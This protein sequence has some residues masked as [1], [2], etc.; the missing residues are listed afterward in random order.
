MAP[1]TRGRANPDYIANA[2]MAEHYAARAACGLIITEGTMTSLKSR[3]WYLAPEIYTEAHANGWKIVTD[4]VH[5]KNGRIFCQLWHTGR[6]GHSNFREGMKQFEDPRAVAPSAIKRASKDGMQRYTNKPGKVEIETPRALETEEVEMLKDE[7][8]N[9]AYWAKQAGFDGVELHCANGYLLDT[10][11]QSCSNERTDKY[12]GSLENRFRVVEEI[13]DGLF[14]VWDKEY[15]GVRISPNGIFNGMGSDD[16]RESFLY[17]AKR[18]AEIGVG[19]LHVMIGLG[20]G[21]HEKGT[22]M[23]MKEFRDVFPGVIIA[24]VDY[25]AETAEKEI[26]EGNADIVAFGRPYLGNPDLVERMKVGAELAPPPPRE[27]FYSEV[28]LE[29][30]APGYTDLPTMDHK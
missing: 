30:G 29:Q 14:E 6:A 16:Y 20:F 18:F 5:E 24:N 26:A 22:P 7:M 9:A 15:V 23:T 27:T 4:A 25:T 19:Y 11:L 21:F 13:L 8:K 12:G 1:M 28:G 3:G 10:F 2:L 17:Y